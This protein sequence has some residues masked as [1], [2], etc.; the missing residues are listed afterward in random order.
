LL[1][2]GVDDVDYAKALIE[3][4][5]REFTC[6]AALSVTAKIMSRRCS[7][8]RTDR[9]PECVHGASRVTH[10]RA[11]G[12]IDP[13]SARVALPTIGSVVWDAAVQA[14]E[15]NEHDVAVGAAKGRIRAVRCPFSDQE[16]AEHAASRLAAVAAAEVAAVGICLARHRVV[17]TSG[18][19]PGPVGAWVA[20][21]MRVG[22]VRNELF[23]GFRH[24]LTTAIKRP[25]DATPVLTILPTPNTPLA[26]EACVNVV[27][28]C[29]RGEAHL[30]L[31]VVKDYVDPAAAL[32]PFEVAILRGLV[33]GLALEAAVTNPELR[34]TW[35]S[36]TLEERAGS[37]SLIGRALLEVTS[38]QERD[39]LLDLARQASHRRQGKP[40]LS[41]ALP[42][43]RRASVLDQ[44]SDP[45]LAGLV[46]WWQAGSTAAVELERLTQIETVVSRFVDD[47]AWSGVETARSATST[48]G[49]LTPS[50]D[51]TAREREILEL[52]VTG[53]RVPSIASQLFI[54]Q[55]TVRNHLSSG[56]KKLGVTSQA[57]F[58][59]LVAVDSV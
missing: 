47:L 24:A 50:E 43:G 55:S 23:P 56:F 11:S 30:A 41:R 36:P 7:T 52:L 12:T 48:V 20:A 8:S 17:W 54:S 26:A 51:L 21:T 16:C 3:L 4:N 35:A 53:L 2:E 25:K 10:E 6:Q 46:W 18:C 38:V 49:R 5:S 45:A 28:H 13:S 42:T 44:T 34:I 29:D 58:L 33:T 31:V 57:E 37:G 19:R 9:A 15:P 22:T 39:V 59:G 1:E 32:P 40:A 14:I 27:D